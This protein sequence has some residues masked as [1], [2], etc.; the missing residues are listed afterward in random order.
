MNEQ[1]IK[2]FYA[3]RVALSGR[4]SDYALLVGQN[5]MA[6]QT[7]TFQCPANASVTALPNA[8][9]ICVSVF[10]LFTPST[11]AAQGKIDWLNPD[12]TVAWSHTVYSKILDIASVTPSPFL[13][14]PYTFNILEFGNFVQQPYKLTSNDASVSLSAL[15]M[16]FVP[17]CCEY[18]GPVGEGSQ[19]PQLKQYF[20]DKQARRRNPG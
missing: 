8:N 16:S 9:R 5:N 15:E 13:Y 11:T 2:D 6:V 12:G 4:L 1:Q 3:Y 10:A 14:F 7:K 18:L 17:K 20:A 19:E